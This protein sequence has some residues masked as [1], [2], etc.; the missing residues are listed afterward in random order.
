MGHSL[1]TSA[2]LVCMVFAAITA[3]AQPPDS[4]SRRHPGNFAS[5]RAEY[6]TSDTAKALVHLF[7]R[8]NRTGKV[9]AYTSGAL[10]V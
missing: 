10:L 8:K 3:M 5:I 9:F 6:G 4:A 2:M 7:R 1:K